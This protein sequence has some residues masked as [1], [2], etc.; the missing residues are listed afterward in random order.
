MIPVVAVIVLAGVWVSGGVISDD[1]RTSMA[2]TA[3][4]F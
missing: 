1:F 4:W 2:L 3:V